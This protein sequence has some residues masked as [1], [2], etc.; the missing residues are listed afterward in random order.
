MKT[1]IWPT[2]MLIWRKKREYQHELRWN[3][4]CIFSF[5][6][7]AATSLFRS[8]AVTFKGS[9]PTFIAR[10]CGTCVSVARSAICFSLLFPY[11]WS[12]NF[13]SLVLYGKFPENG[14][15]FLFHDQ[16]EN[17]SY[18]LHVEQLSI[19]HTAFLFVFFS[20]EMFTLS[21]ITPLTGSTSPTKDL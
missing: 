19:I 13:Y 4:H 18:L 1:L 21:I 2:F 9:Q 17:A 3:P 15:S 12:M 11:C 20:V 8:T 14:T 7:M 16:I 6:K 5:T 10:M